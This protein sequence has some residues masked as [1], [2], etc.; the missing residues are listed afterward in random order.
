M[1]QPRSLRNPPV[2]EA[3]FDLTVG[4]PSPSDPSRFADLQQDISSQYPNRQTR[5]AFA[6]QVTAG[7]SPIA[8]ALDAA[9]F[10]FRSADNSRAVQSKPD[11]YTFSQLKPYQGWES[12]ISEALR[13]WELY[14][15]RFQPQRVL[16]LSL[17]FINRMPLP[18]PRL[19]FDDYIITSPRIPSEL[20][21][22][23]SEFSVSYVVPVGTKTICRLRIRF[24][25]GEMTSTEVPL[26]LDLDILR[27]CDTDP[28]N[29]AELTEN[30]ANLRV[31]KNHVFFGTLTEKAIGLFE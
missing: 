22:E 27:E 25:S 6:F 23:L 7:H 24:S 21:Q 28:A 20:P 4:F 2:V 1:A 8:N 19:D 16:R 5:H 10:V 31:L 14:R 9:G 11:G 13:V 18:G 3:I 17:R 26:W 12:A 30:F 29:L 15:K